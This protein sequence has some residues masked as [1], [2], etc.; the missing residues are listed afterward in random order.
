MLFL[1]I[2]IEIVTLLCKIGSIKTVGQSLLLQTDAS[3]TIQDRNL[4]NKVKGQYVRDMQ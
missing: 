2:T 3:N 4:E 1:Y